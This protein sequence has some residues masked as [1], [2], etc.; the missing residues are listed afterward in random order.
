MQTLSIINLILSLLIGLVRILF[1]IRSCFQNS[2]SK[3]RLG[4]VIER[5]P[6]DE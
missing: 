6:V 5:T 4:I 2:D 3:S 1:I